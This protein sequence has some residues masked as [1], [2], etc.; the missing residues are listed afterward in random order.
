VSATRAPNS[1]R[2]L[3]KGDDAFRYLK[4]SAEKAAANLQQFTEALETPDEEVPQ[5]GVAENNQ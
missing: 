2:F 4:G 3:S 5:E 1:I